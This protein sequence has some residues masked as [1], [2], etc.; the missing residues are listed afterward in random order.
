MNGGY[1]RW[2]EATML[3]WIIIVSVL[4]LYSC[5]GI[6]FGISIFGKVLTPPYFPCPGLNCTTT[7]FL[8][9]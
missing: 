4:G 9:W 2:V 7:V 5:F 1:P 8:Q 6:Q 3:K